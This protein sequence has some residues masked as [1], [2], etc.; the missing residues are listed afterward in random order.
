MS[1]CVREHP[2]GAVLQIRVVP[3][4]SSAKVVG[5]HGAELKVRVCSPPVDGRANDEVIQV[6]AAALRVRAREIELIAGHSA[7]SKQLLFGLPAIELRRRVESL[8]N[9]VDPAI[10]TLSAPER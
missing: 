8:T 10:G 2:D 1:D 6:V 7:R 5:R 4:A 3:G 9:P